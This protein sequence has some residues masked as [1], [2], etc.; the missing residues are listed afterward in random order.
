MR[1]S[2]DE[3]LLTGELRNLRERWGDQPCSH[4][5]FAREYYEDVPTGDLACMICGETFPVDNLE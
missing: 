4:P 3:V 5:R 2:P 1:I